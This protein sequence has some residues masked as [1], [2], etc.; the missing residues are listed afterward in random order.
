MCECQ[1]QVT[2][3]KLVNMPVYL[4]VSSRSV[5]CNY[6][7][8]TE[9]G[10]HRQTF[11]LLCHCLQVNCIVHLWSW[12]LINKQSAMSSALLLFHKMIPFY[13]DYSNQDTVSLTLRYSCLLIMR[14]CLGR[15]LDSLSQS[16]ERRDDE[17]LHG[18]C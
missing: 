7:I 2:E 16:D 5:A 13:N 6:I 10:H 17:R 3:G 18:R 15:Y 1:G 4:I 11:N 9:T 14:T 12:K 8:M